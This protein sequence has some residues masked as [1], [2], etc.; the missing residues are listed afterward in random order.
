MR[1]PKVFLQIGMAALIVASIFSRVHNDA[2]FGFF[3][4]VSIGCNL[5]FV[6]MRCHS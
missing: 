2:L 4:G 5:L 6:R 1:N 3:T